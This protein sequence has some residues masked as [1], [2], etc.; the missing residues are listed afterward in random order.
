[1]MHKIKHSHLPILVIVL[2]LLAVGC[3]LV[4]IRLDVRKCVAVF[5]LSYDVLMECSDRFFRL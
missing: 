1:M 4:V 5:D 2:C 3:S